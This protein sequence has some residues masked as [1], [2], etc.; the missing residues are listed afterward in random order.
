MF[1][2]CFNTTILLSDPFLTR[3]LLSD[4]FLTRFR[5]GGDTLCLPNAFLLSRAKAVR[6]GT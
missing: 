2:P 3:F 6:V 5:S 1:S 4:P